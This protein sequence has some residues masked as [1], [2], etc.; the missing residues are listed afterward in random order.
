VVN[1]TSKR[2]SRPHTQAT[3]LA[4]GWSTASRQRSGQAASS[5]P[6]PPPRSRG[7]TPADRDP[8][9]D[10]GRVGSGREARERVVTVARRMDHDNDGRCTV[11]KP[12]M[13]VSGFVSP[14]APSIPGDWP[15][16]VRTRPT[17]WPAP[18]PSWRADRSTPPEC[19]SGPY[20]PSAP[21]GSHPGPPRAALRAGSAGRVSTA[22]CLRPGRRRR[23]LAP[24]CPSPRDQQHRARTPDGVRPPSEIRPT[25]TRCPLTRFV[26]G[27]AVLSGSPSVCAG[28]GLT[29]SFVR[30]GA[31]PWQPAPSRDPQLS[32][33]TAESTR[34]PTGCGRLCSRS[35]VHCM[36]CPRGFAGVFGDPDCMATLLRE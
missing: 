34:P 28:S 14:R 35:P 29:R 16:S 4:V 8:H 21:E 36:R 15:R 19:S 2:Q 12:I 22:S 17:R 11:P 13:R 25:F 30:W 6:R 5:V 26:R 33:R 32:R 10:D 3:S 31:P 9:E 27:A 1:S 24:P 23:P 7:P 18:G 20:R